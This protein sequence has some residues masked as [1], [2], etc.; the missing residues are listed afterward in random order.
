MRD[1]DRAGTSVEATLIAKAAAA[2]HNASLGLGW[3]GTKGTE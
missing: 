1:A 3:K 2:I